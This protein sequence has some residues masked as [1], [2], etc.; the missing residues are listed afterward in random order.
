MSNIITVVKT[1]K[2]LLI[3]KVN[4]KCIY[5]QKLLIFL[6]FC[7]FSSTGWHDHPG[8]QRRPLERRVRG[9]STGTKSGTTFDLRKPRLNVV[10]IS[11]VDS[12]STSTAAKPEG[13]LSHCRT[14]SQPD[15]A[16][17]A[18]KTIPK[19]GQVS[20]VESCRC[21]LSK[22]DRFCDGQRLVEEK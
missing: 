7:L 4:L 1:V 17:A 8:S 5:D 20:R 21:R 16:G 11:S 2:F 22:I 6:S 18:E 10:R 19:C 13:F 15:P 12:G 3:L 14:D 9:S